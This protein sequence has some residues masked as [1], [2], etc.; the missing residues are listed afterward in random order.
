[1][2]RGKTEE[3]DKPAV[4]GEPNPSLLALVPLA[5]SSSNCQLITF[6]HN[7]Q[8]SS[9][10]VLGP[11]KHLSSHHNEHQHLQPSLSPGPHS[12]LPTPPPPTPHSSHTYLGSICIHTSWFSNLPNTSQDGGVGGGGAGTGGEGGLEAGHTRGRW[13]LSLSR[14]NVPSGGGP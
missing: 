5:R 13:D 10:C 3:S 14:T 8:M 1:M 7:I 11:R 9:P 4:T 12:P 6:L 2:L